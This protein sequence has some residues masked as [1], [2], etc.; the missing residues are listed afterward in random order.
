MATTI[1]I[2]VSVPALPEGSRM[3]PDEFAQWLA[4]SFVF[5]AVGTFLTGQTGGAEPTTDVGI[6]LH[7][8]TISLWNETKAAY[9]PLDTVP[10]GGG[11]EFYG[12]ALPDNY[13][14][15]DGAE[16][17]KVDYADLYAVLGDTWKKTGDSDGNFRVPDH[18]GRVGV[19]AGIG[20][21]DPKNATGG[22]AATGKTTER[23][24]GDYWGWEWANSRQVTQANAPATTPPIREADTRLVRKNTT[25]YNGVNQPSLAC[26]YIIRAK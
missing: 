16:Y 14:W 9:A 23:S 6:W 21:Y 2:T 1:A 3:T 12:A 20:D 19:G 24:L 11:L 7:D 26:H 15:Q 13:L 22:W 5:E 18:R 8:G 4:E 25:F 17:A 10:V